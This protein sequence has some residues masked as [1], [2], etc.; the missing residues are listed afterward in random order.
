MAKKQELEQKKQTARLYYMQGESQK[1]IAELVGISEATICKWVNDGGWAQFRAARSMSRQELI[2]KMLANANAKLDAGTMS[3]DEMVK[4]ASAI[5]KIDKKNNVITF[6]EVVTVINRW[7]DSRVEIEEKLARAEGREPE[8]TPELVK[9]INKYHD[10][11]INE[12][13]MSVELKVEELM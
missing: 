4:V 11:F 12:K 8:L 6:I 7:L 2:I 9:L 1:K 10:M 3:A 5:E 13:L